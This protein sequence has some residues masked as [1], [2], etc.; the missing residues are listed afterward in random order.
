MVGVMM[1]PRKLPR[2][3]LIDT[4]V[5]TR[6]IGDL[7]PDPFTADCRDFWKAMLTADRELLIAAPSLAEVIR[8][9][10]KRSIPRAPQIEVIAFDQAAAELLGRSFPISV[11]KQ[12]NHAGTTLTHLKYDALIVASAARYN[13]DSVVALD[14]DIFKLVEYVGLTAHRP[15]DFRLP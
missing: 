6:A 11:L 12:H 9:D 10:G 3:S 13:A 4:G 1:D 5:L 2:R 7:P 14:P 8:L 15:G